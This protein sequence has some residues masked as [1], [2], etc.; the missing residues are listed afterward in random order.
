MGM[1]KTNPFLM[2]VGQ[3]FISLPAYRCM[4]QNITLGKV[5]MGKNSNIATILFPGFLMFSYITFLFGKKLNDAEFMT[6]P[7][8]LFTLSGLSSIVHV[9]NIFFLPSS[10][11]PDPVPDDY[12][13]FED[14][15][16]GK[17]FGEKYK[18][19][20]TTK[21][22]M[23][24]NE[25]KINVRKVFEMLLTPRFF[26]I[27]VVNILVWHRSAAAIGQFN[28]WLD[29]AYYE[30]SL[31]CEND[32]GDDCFVDQYKSDIID[33]Y[34]YMNCLHIVLP[35]GIVALLSCFKKCY[36][37]DE[38]GIKSILTSFI[39]QLS[40]SLLHVVAI[41]AIMMMKIP[42]GG[43]KGLPLLL[44]TLITTLQPIF[45]SCPQIVNRIPLH[46]NNPFL[47]RLHIL[48]ASSCTEDLHC[49]QSFLSAH[50]I[51]SNSY[52]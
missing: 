16:V 18:T 2:F 37:S 15:I 7:V 11:V 35:F 4:S 26:C 6:L 12:N 8:F 5:Y 47:V 45:M 22:E 19:L 52:L 14:S 27:T 48:S 44:A 21:Q 49:Y 30:D 43:G 23:I 42:A 28:A 29:Y 33:I 24:K 36:A 51:Y 10:A 46:F 17:C 34:G 3:L 13:I 39:F 50:R 1:Y 25:N 32:P 38:S 41:T 20:E 31:L 40:M 9:R